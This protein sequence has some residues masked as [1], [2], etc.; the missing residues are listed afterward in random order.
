MQ[1]LRWPALFCALLLTFSSAVAQQKVLELA[2]FPRSALTI[3]SAGK[4]HTFN[5]WIADT[6]ERQSQGL[7]F[8]RD[9]PASE[10]MLFTHA[11]P[12]LASMWMKNTYIPLDLL[13]IDA[14]GRIVRIFERTIPQS[15]Q[16][17]S[18]SEPVTGVLELRGGEVAKRGIR[19]GDRVQHPHFRAH[20]RR[21]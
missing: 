18:A 9:L 20:E 14:R 17:L 3:T 2:S 10:A 6:P 7:M 13:F 1:A 5:V 16:T 4:A 11:E 8:V 21:Q 19:V 15:L 12:R